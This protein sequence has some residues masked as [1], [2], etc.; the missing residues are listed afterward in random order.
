MN[1]V[2]D[3]NS[4]IHYAQVDRWIVAVLVGA[5]LLEAGVAATFLVDGLSTGDLAP[6]AA[7]AIGCIPFGLGLLMGL[8]LRALYNIRYEISPSD[9][10]VHC[11]PFRTT[12]PL[13]TI[14]EVFPTRNPISAAA[15]SIDR[16]QINSRKTNGAMRLTLISP[17]DR[18]GFVRDLASAAPRLRRV[19]DGALRLK[20]EEPA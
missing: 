13:D 19:G 3:S 1:S 5:V 18:E 11:G 10:V 12:L 9:L 4:I 16:L 6:A 20:A 7:V 15:P 8:F 14:V 17:K 2:S